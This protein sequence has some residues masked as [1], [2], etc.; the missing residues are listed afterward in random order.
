MEEI[1]LEI[2]VELLSS[3]IANKQIK[4]LR[5]IFSEYNIVDLAELVSQLS[6]NEVLYV[7]KILNREITAD[8]FSYL[9]S[10]QQELLI[11]TMSAPEINKILEN[12]FADDITDIVGEMPPNITKKLLSSVSAQQRKEINWLL[13]YQEFSAG[14]LMSL[15]YVELSAGDDVTSALNKIKHQEKLAETISTCF[16]V[17]NNDLLLGTIDIKT[18][19]FAPENAIIE[20]LMETDFAVVTTHDDQ[21]AVAKT[22]RKYDITVVPVVDEGHHMVGIITVDDIVDIIEEEATE[23]FHRM[24]A[25]QPLEGSYLETSSFEMFK[26]RITWLLVLMVSSTVSGTIMIMNG[27]TLQHLPTLATFIPMLMDTSGNAGSQAS[28]MVIRG[29]V[30]DD[31]TIKDFFKVF[32]KELQVSI[33]CGV[34]LGLV[35]MAR[36]MLF[37][38]AVGWVMAGMVSF[39]VFMAVVIAKLVGGLL[40]LLALVI[41]QDPASMAAPIITTISDAL[42]LTVYFSL[43]TWLLLR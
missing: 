38:P 43:A 32:F 26:S 34:I 6:A 36:I 19:L 41:R 42:S 17:D 35:N 10:D 23:D 15:D 1:Q 28:A 14:S 27:G 21:E 31:L 22:I 3:L 2:T 18:V 9:E 8:L 13:S 39:T 40:P 11:E 25:V 16:V 7:I 30:V 37:S 12:M 4:R 20:E 5:E 33:I 24:A 29:I